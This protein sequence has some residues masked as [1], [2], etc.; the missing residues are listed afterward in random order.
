MQIGFEWSVRSADDLLVLVLEFVEVRVWSVVD[1]DDVA[2]Q[3][4]DSSLA[5]GFTQL[6]AEAEEEVETGLGP[7]AGDGDCAFV[8]SGA[9]RQSSGAYRSGR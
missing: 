3:L 6:D 1:E 5:T 7:A 8:L 2:Q 4:S 9:A